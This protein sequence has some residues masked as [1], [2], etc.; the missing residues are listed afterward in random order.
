MKKTAIA[1]AFM[2]SVANAATV[3]G[4]GEYRFGP[5]TAENVACAI[6][7]DRAKE[8]VLA[9][10]VGEFIE[11]TTNEICKDDHC[12][13]YRSFY[14]ETYGKIKQ[15]KDKQ[16]L[17]APEK[18]ASVCNVTLVADV[19]KVENKIQ[20]SIEGKSKF[21]SGEKF[22]MTAV[23]NVKGRYAVF[24]FERDTYVLVNENKVVEL[25]REIRIP[26][27]GKFEAFVEPNLYQSN[28]LLVFLFTKDELT[29]KPRYSKIEFEHMVKTL[30]F[31]RRKLVN[32]QINI[33]R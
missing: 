21:R 1:L 22:A 31:T 26:A 19:V 10:F 25:N 23:S 18:S 17:V 2:C 5:E 33:V 12:S 20:F 13:Q 8:N 7:E 24:S 4:E 16:V 28:E 32:H 27:I 6:A 3:T 30:D 15:I 14:S 9:N 11:H 29:F